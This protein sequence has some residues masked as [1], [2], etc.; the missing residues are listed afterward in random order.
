MGIEIVMGSEAKRLIIWAETESGAWCHIDDA[1][2]RD[3]Y[4]CIA[5]H[6]PLTFRQGQE[7]IYHF[8]HRSSCACFG[9]SVIHAMAKE[10]VVSAKSI[11]LP[12]VSGE[13]VVKHNNNREYYDYDVPELASPFRILRGA[14]EKKVSA[15]WICDAFCI[16]HS[17][18]AVAV[19][20]RYTNKKDGRD[21]EKF[22]GHDISVV[23]IDVRDF[24]LGLS[25]EDAKHWVR[26]E[27]PRN[28]LFCPP[29]ELARNK[30]QDHAWAEVFKRYYANSRSGKRTKR[31][32]A[33]I[34]KHVADPL[35]RFESAIISYAK[36][37]RAYIRVSPIYAKRGENLNHL[38]ELPKFDP[39]V[40]SVKKFEINPK[41][42][43]SGV[44]EI[45][46]ELKGGVKEYPFFYIEN[47]AAFDVLTKPNG[48]FA[49]VFHDESKRKR[50]YVIHFKNVERWS[51]R[52]T[53]LFRY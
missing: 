12:D 49:V 15:D 19:E 2:K 37:Y 8:A 38:V 50:Q 26:F 43:W 42:G 31:P 17:E 22:K 44:I 53:K 16:G 39:E 27:A 1:N 32:Q 41:F 6:R 40:V 47:K 51:E 4:Q 9:E 23:E 35:P 33:E 3:R 11:R 48:P 45:Y 7:R 28:W 25:L 34:K 36:G 29:R 21:I 52:L 14:T 13:G 5:C 10:I 20:I 24:D 30:A 18:I 46:N